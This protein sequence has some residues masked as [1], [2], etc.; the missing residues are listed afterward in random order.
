MTAA[1]KNNT[2]SS[3]GGDA[4]AQAESTPPVKKIIGMTLYFHLC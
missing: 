2:T 1:E 4:P 3:G